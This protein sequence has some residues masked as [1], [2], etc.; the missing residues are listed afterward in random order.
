MKR[1]AQG[2]LDT[3]KWMQEFSVASNLDL[4]GDISDNGTGIGVNLATEF[5]LTGRPFFAGKILHQYM[6]S[7]LDVATSAGTE[8]QQ[9]GGNNIYDIE[10][11]ET[12]LYALTSL[13]VTINM[14]NALE[15]CLT[16]AN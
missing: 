12:V 5:A 3:L 14:S 9:H 6:I 7:L 10:H 2:A 13:G 11:D 4:S 8:L 16:S 15:A 1:A